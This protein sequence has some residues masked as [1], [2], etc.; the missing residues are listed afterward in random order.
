M[1]TKIVNLVAA[2]MLLAGSLQAGESFIGLGYASADMDGVSGSGVVLDMGAKFGETFK[3]KFGVR[4][5]FLGENKDLR[6]GQGNIGDIY[7]SLGFEVL[8]STIIS[9]NVGYGFQSLGSVGTGS[10]KT[11]AYATGLSY[12][13][14]LTYEISKYFDVALNYTKN[15]L[16][17]LESSY[18]V[19][20]VD[21][22]VSYKF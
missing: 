12:G 10:S 18:A 14:S 16:S 4:Y 15:D 19:D 21:A 13:G 1:K 7:Y 6:D 8:S 3:Q 17:Y 20:I 11:T 22:S 2:S 9:A 5:V